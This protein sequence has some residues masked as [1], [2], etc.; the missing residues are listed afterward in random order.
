MVRIHFSEGAGPI[1]VTGEIANADFANKLNQQIA[2]SKLRRDF[3]RL[4]VG[5]MSTYFDPNR[6][7]RVDFFPE[8]TSDKAKA[9][10]QSAMDLAL[11]EQKKDGGSPA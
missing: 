9:D 1:T 10:L 8:V 7:V 6:V 2:Q 11:R 5:A 3:V 4:D